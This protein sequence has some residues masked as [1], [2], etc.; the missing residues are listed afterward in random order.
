MLIKTRNYFSRRNY[1]TQRIDHGSI[2]ITRSKMFFKS[3]EMWRM[4][5]RANLRAG[6]GSGWSLF[7]HGLF[8]SKLS[9]TFSFSNTLSMFRWFGGTFKF[10]FM[11]LVFS[12]T[13]V[14]PRGWA[15]E[16]QAILNSDQLVKE[17]AKSICRIAEILPWTEVAVL[18]YPTARIKIGV[19]QIYKHILRFTQKA[20]AWYK[21]G[22]VAHAMH[23]I[24]KPWE[25]QFEDDVIAIQEQSLIIEADA[26]VASRAE[27]RDAHLQ[28]YKLQSQLNEMMLV[29]AQSKQI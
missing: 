8:T 2:I 18:L 11:V 14:F 17:L 26:S 6:Q 12:P 4:R 29:L 10:L 16:R 28:I 25:L 22:K 15:N 19:A 3:W 27:L 5:M 1:H 20:I 9:L 23:A 24:V 7:R 13:W 21:R